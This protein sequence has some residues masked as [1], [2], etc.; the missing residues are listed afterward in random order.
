MLTPEQLAHCA[1]DI[2]E[3]YSKLEEEI[4]RDISR[5]IA[6]TG[7]MT[8]TAIW[9]TK[10]MQELGALNSD[11]LSSISK[12]S[13]KCESE[14]KKLFEN[15]GIIATE[16]DNEIYRAHG[17]NPKSIKVSDTQLQILEAGFKKTQDN[18]SNLTKT[19]A[20]SSQTS[21]I[22]A[23]SLAELKATSGAFSPQQAIIDAIRQVA[24]K[25][26]EVIY[27]SGHIDKLDVAVR[28]NVMTGIGQ[29]TGEI[30]LANARELGCDL[31]EITAHAG[32]RPSHS[33][34][35]GQI[36]SLSGRKGYLSLSDIGYGTGD[37]FKGWN[38]RHDWYPYFEGSTRMY[39]EEKLKQMDAKNIQYPDGSMHTLYEAEQKQR[40]YERKIRESKR[41]LAAYDEKIKG[42]EDNAK[43]KA[44]QNIFDKESVKLK[45]R[46][47]E[48]DNFCDKTGLLKRSD[49]VQKYGFGR[50]T[51]QKAVKA[52]KKQK[53]KAAA[54]SAIRNT[55]KRLSFNSNAKFEIVLE[56]YD[57]K[58][59][60]GLSK[61]SKKVAE[62]GGKDGKEH[63]S[64]INLETGK[65]EY[66]ETGSE[67]FVGG[68][69]FFKFLS[70]NPNKKYA[71]IH[72][73]NEDGYFSERDLTTLLTTD[74]ISVFAAIRIDGVCYVTE[75]NETLKNV[76]FWDKLFPDEINSLNKKYRDG[77]IT[78][79][80]R[81]RMR[82]EIIV[83]GLLQK[84]TKGLIELG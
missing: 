2:V 77:I 41:I 10:H 69:E 7:I 55:G 49:R 83:D 44:Y 75:K 67:Q 18:L 54:N 9:Q 39:D 17:L 64:L 25:G 27:P 66:F 40:A 70:E 53:M 21:F 45:R 36:V 3:L 74:N 52:N 73:H 42:A 78:A 82:E 8:D 19:T 71:F 65:E 68:S 23:C 81:T 14:L 43:R 59:L 29:T 13:G 26:A 80:E 37:G 30:C 84:Y 56:G 15:A 22:N 48:L 12:Y 20:V 32:A 72:N 63:L 79:G 61:A 76:S 1:D 33:Y 28:R 16:Y 50:S 58:V 38:C 34:W 24:V 57:N 11:I 35:Q 60:S 62:L 4:V 46:E 6:K 31:M 5:R 51:A 47:S